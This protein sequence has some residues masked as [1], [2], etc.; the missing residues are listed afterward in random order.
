A[1]DEPRTAFRA[2]VASEKFSDPHLMQARD[3][4]PASS[5]VR[6]VIS[7]LRAKSE[8]CPALSASGQA[9]N[10][11][12]SASFIQVPTSSDALRVCEDSSASECAALVLD[13]VRGPCEE[14]V[15]ES[16]LARGASR[17]RALLI[18][19]NRRSQRPS[20]QPQPPPFRWNWAAKGTP[21]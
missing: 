20:R 13:V 9:Q 7:S 4:S 3:A 21:I 17:G 19:W 16:S 14:D 10:R 8:T 1:D 2:V 11:P 15:G 18:R 12:S 6:L 5:R